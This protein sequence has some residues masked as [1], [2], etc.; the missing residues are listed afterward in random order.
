MVLTSANQR[1]GI[2]T[3]PSKWTKEQIAVM[4][5]ERYLEISAYSLF[6]IWSQLP[7]TLQQDQELQSHLPCFQHYNQSTKLVHIDG[8]P[9]SKLYCRDCIIL[10]KDN[11][12]SQNTIKAT[13]KQSL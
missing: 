4:P 3:H 11:R 9:P 6:Q 2:R 13:R 5:K 7:E 10:H 1:V 8:P 12:P